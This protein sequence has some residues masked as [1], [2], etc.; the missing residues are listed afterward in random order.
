[1]LFHLGAGL[2]AEFESAYRARHRLWC[3]RKSATRDPCVSKWETVNDIEEGA[4]PRALGYTSRQRSS[5]GGS[6]ANTDEL[7]SVGEVGFEQG[8]SSTGDVQGGSVR[9]QAWN[10]WRTSL[11]P[12]Q[13]G[14][15]PV[16]T[17]TLQLI[18]MQIRQEAPEMSLPRRQA[19]MF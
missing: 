17:I 4:E 5:G 10:G 1:M 18:L 9:N 3:Q 11:A 19:D 13:P 7:L 12:G 15:G 2:V 16:A 14:S 8:E 6:I